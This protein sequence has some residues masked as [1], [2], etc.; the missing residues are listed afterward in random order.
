MDKSTTRRVCAC[1]I[2]LFLMILMGCGSSSDTATVS[3]KVTLDGEPVATG[4]VSFYPQESGGGATTSCAI[5]DGQYRIADLVP[6]KKKIVVMVNTGTP[7][8]PQQPT[9]EVSRE[10]R[11]AERRGEVRKRDTS[12]ASSRKPLIG[13]NKVVDILQGKQEV[14]IPLQKPK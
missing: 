6:G 5:K 1:F 7:T 10:S 11:N 9:G 14:H 2:P 3:G 13:N 8:A 12:P 4:S